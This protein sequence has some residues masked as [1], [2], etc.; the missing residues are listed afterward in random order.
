[1]PPVDGEPPSAAA[2]VFAPAGFAPED[3]LEPEDFEPESLE[4]DD[5]EPD[6]FEP[7]EA[8]DRELSDP[9]RLDPERFVPPVGVP[10]E[11]PAESAAPGCVTVAAVFAVVSS[12]PHPAVTRTRIRPI[13][14]VS[15]RCIA[16]TMASG[17]PAVAPA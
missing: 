7:V 8:F 3:V 11:L 14:A 9:E 2:G 4:L 12:L 15:R 10:T 13:V 6:A 16:G 5:F 1:V 17:G